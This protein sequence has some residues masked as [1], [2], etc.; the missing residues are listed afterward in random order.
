M[1]EYCRVI[2]LCSNTFRRYVGKYNML[3]GIF[4]NMLHLL[5]RPLIIC[6]SLW[7]I[8]LTFA[9]SDFLNSLF[10]LIIIMNNEILL[11]IPPC[12]CR[13]LV[14]DY[15]FMHLELIPMLVGFFTYKIATFIQAIQEAVRV[16]EEKPQA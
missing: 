7:R 8:L 3:K 12:N 14:P 5:K 13:I 9:C 10:L 4:L 1:T 2:I 15:G 16:V 11:P 6:Y